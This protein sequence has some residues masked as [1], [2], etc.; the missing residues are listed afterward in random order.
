[1]DKLKVLNTNIIVLA[2][3]PPKVGGPYIWYYRICELLLK[4]GYRIFTLGGAG[5]PPPGVYNL[6]H[7]QIGLAFLK[8]FLLF[9]DVLIEGMSEYKILIYLIR[10][11]LLRI[12]DFMYIVSFLAMI[13][14]NWSNLPKE[15]G[16]VLAS[17]INI[18]SLLAYLICRKHGRFKLVIREHGGGILEFAAKRPELVQFLLSK[19]DYVNCVSEY[20]ANECRKKGV[21]SN[22]LKV[23]LSARDIPQIDEKVKKENIV[24][25]CGFLEPRKD[26]MTYLKA[27]KEF[28]HLYTSSEKPKFIVIG[29]GSLKTQMQDFCQENDLEKFVEF[30]GLLPLEQVWDWMMKSKVLVLSSVREPSGAVLTEAMAYRCY[31]IASRVG[32]IPE[33]V[34]PERGGLFEPGD[35]KQLAQLVADFFNKEETYIPK[36]SS[37]YQYVKENYSFE[38]AAEQLNEIFEKI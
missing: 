11:G 1:M 28:I 7:K 5:N 24:L 32:G 29:D 31:C 3:F 36:I 37:A 18:N 10:K 14:R 13:K 34:T 12:S 38:K 2:D 35:Y 22:R 6:N 9:K 20:I 19:A 4:K 30:T 23:I 15:E 26:P 21:P 17:H 8:P 16:I 33:I 25:F 27:V